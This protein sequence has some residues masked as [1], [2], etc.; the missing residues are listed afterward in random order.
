MY[1]QPSPFTFPIDTSSNS[2]A[3]PNMAF[4]APTQA[5]QLDPAVE[6]MLANYFPQNP[7]SNAGGMAGP[8]TVPQVP[9][10]F[11]SRVFSFSWENNNANNNAA[12]GHGN[13]N[14]NNSGNN[15]NGQGQ[16][17]MGGAGQMNGGA[18][19]LDALGGF[20]APGMPFEQWGSGGWMA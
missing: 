12:N 19:G 18:G 14:G 11:L 7:Q 10:D 8:A 13:A 5:P 17:G 4:L 6:S 2:Y 20:G 9:D 1:Q 15:G 16:G 3:P